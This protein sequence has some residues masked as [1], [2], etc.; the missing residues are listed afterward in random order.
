MIVRTFQRVFGTSLALAMART[1][2]T[3]RPMK[4]LQSPSRTAA[5]LAQLLERLDA[6]RVPVDAHQYRTV[7]ARLVE[8]LSDDSVDWQPLL[9][10]SPAAATVY[11][12]MFYNE[13]GLCRSPLDA[14]MNAELQARKAIDVARRTPSGPAADSAA[15]DAA[16]AA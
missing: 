3:C 10:E 7:V 14:A 2:P 15:P 4:T 8:F 16:P 6:S 9:D 5:V 11:E 12:N 1:A 13:A